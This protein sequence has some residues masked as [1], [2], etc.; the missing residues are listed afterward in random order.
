MATAQAV[1]AAQPDSAATWEEF[2]GGHLVFVAKDYPVGRAHGL[3]FSGKV[4]DDDIEH[5]EQFYFRHGAA[6]QVDVSPYADSSLFE[7][8]NRRGF[9]VAEFNQTLA[10]RISPQEQFAAQLEGIEIRAVRPEEAGTWCKVLA[11]VFFAE[12]A[13]RYESMFAPWASKNPLALAAFSSEQMIAG[14]GGLL[15][16]KHDVAAFFGAATLPQF[17]GRGIQA[18]FMQERLR[19]AQQA[20]SDLAVTLT[21]PGTASQ[22]NAERAGFRTAYT[23]VVVIKA[24]N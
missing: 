12:N 4:T 18:A 9:Q 5:V 13:A 1:K 21:L 3:G 24:P 15:V 8:L 7:A 16:P 22:R 14:A 17:Q 6:A 10:R 19:V 11:Q 23:K 2:G 20:G